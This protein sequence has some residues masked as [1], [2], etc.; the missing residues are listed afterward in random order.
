[1]GSL[2][3]WYVRR[4]LHD[5]CGSDGQCTALH[6]QID[7]HIREV[8]VD[9]FRFMNRVEAVLRF[10]ARKY[11]P[12]GWRDVPNQKFLDAYVRHMHATDEYDHESGMP[13]SWHAACNL[14]ILL[15]KKMEGQ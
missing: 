4:Q 3:P 1:M 5:R 9:V 7:W 11:K 13:H 10:G 14:V 6:R 15:A 12:Y 2:I 8:H